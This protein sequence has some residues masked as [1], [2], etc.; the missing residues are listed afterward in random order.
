[1]WNFPS[2]PWFRAFPAIQ[3]NRPG[4]QLY[5]KRPQQTFILMKTSWRRLEE[6]RRLDQDEYVRLSLIPAN[7]R[8]G[9]DVLKTSSRRLQC[10]IFLS[11]KTSWR[12]NC[13]TSCKHV[14]KTSWRHNCK[15]SYKH[16]L[17]T[18]WR[19]F[20]KTYRKYVLKT[21]WKTKS[22]TLK[23]SS[24]RLQDVLENKKCLLGHKEWV[25]L[26]TSG[27]SQA[28]LLDLV[29]S[30]SLS[31]FIKRY[32]V[33][34]ITSSR[35]W[36][37]ILFWLKVKNS[38]MGLVSIESQMWRGMEGFLKAWLGVQRSYFRKCWRVANWIMGSYRKV[39][40]K[41]RLYWIADR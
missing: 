20:R 27:S 4:L 22:V 39:Y 24:R 3:R 17:K 23:T 38:W 40:W 37:A 21:S 25:T 2:F 36:V 32:K 13:K 10:N 31:D 41:L 16:V 11:S 33:F 14:L 9:E 28:L 5:L 6:V 34:K 1:M 26:H 29:P 18:S 7:I 15:T 35:M 8:L 12:H 30:K 19:R